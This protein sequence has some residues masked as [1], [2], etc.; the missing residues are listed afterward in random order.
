MAEPL[1]KGDEFRCPHCKKIV[2]MSDENC[3]SCGA[4]ME[5][6]KAGEFRCGHCREIVKA[7]DKRCPTCGN[8]T[9]P[10]GQ[11]VTWMVVALIIGIGLVGWFPIMRA[12]TG[13]FYVP[14][15]MTTLFN[16]IGI[17]S[18]IVAVGCSVLLVVTKKMKKKKLAEMGI[19]Q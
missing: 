15:S 18:I 1:L 2:K 3:P 13:D 12:F 4:K 19:A 8:K 9:D 5:K 16:G 17:V 10:T 7:T 6:L 14:T 11:L